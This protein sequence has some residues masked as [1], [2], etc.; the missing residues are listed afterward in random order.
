MSKR[1]KDVRQLELP[2]PEFI[3]DTIKYNVKRVLLELLPYKKT[4]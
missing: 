3:E 2:F 1:S 4:N